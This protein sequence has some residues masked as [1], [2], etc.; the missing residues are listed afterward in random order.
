[1]VLGCLDWSGGENVVPLSSCLTFQS[2]LKDAAMPDLTNN[3]FKQI[4]LGEDSVLELKRVGI[5]GLTD[6]HTSLK[7]DKLQKLNNRRKINANHTI[8][9]EI[10]SNRM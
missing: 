8:K 9:P 4:A 3:L 6:Q 10:I 7:P 5:Q 1:M 2:A